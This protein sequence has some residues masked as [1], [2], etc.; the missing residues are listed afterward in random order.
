MA[1]KTWA[2]NHV[3]E[4]LKRYGKEIV[5]V[6]LPYDWQRPG[7]PM[8]R[9]S[10]CSLPEEAV[11]YLTTDNPRLLELQARYKA[12]NENVTTPFAWTED[13]IRPQ[14][15]SFF[16][17]DTAWLW[18]AR[19]N[20]ANVPAYAL[21]WYY[22]KSIDR[23]GL[24]DRQSEDDS[25]GCLTL[26]VD[27]RPVSRDLIDSLFEIYFLDRHL[28][29]GSGTGLRVLD[30]GAGY[31]RLAHR[32]TSALPG[33]DRYLCT[34]AIA[35]S[36][37]VSEYYLRY[38]GAERASVVPLDEIEQRLADC[39]VDLAINIHSFSECRLA[40][41]EWWIRLLSQHRVRYLM[42]VPND[43][44]ELMTSE[45]YDFLPLLESYGYRKVVK[46]PKFLDPVIQK[47]GILPSWNHLLELRS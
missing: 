1:V 40:A 2:K 5:S 39:P 26:P 28:G 27:G 32:M 12:F 44:E 25:F 29:I 18:Q 16:R 10:A 42:I 4:L 30:I 3:N 6:D 9:E 31:G 35:A 11:R 8:P 23:L 34:D 14:D 37:F 7:E 15:I 24:L 22:L 17:G 41:I 45:G 21:T 38:R 13:A 36:S 20:N 33:V 46:E 19:G 47:Y 43:W